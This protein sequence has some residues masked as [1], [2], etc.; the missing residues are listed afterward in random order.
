ML[1]AFEAKVSSP[2]TKRKVT[3]EKVN[4]NRLL[5]DGFTALLDESG[6]SL[7]QEGTYEFPDFEG[8]QLSLDTATYPILQFKNNATI[9]VDTENR[10]PAEIKEVI[11]SNW[12]NH[13]IIPFGKDRHLESILD[14]LLKEMSFFIIKLPA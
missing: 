11:Q 6:S 3:L 4:I 9:I 14:Q 13:K 10:L 5:K 7:Q 2:K 8:S 1:K 12:S